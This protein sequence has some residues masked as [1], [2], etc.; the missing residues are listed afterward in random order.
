M[1]GPRRGLPHG[2]PLNTELLYYLAVFAVMSAVIIGAGVLLAKTE[3]VRSETP[4]EEDNWV[5]GL[6]WAEARGADLETW[7]FL[8]GDAQTV[9]KVIEAYKIGWTKAEA[10][11]F[12]DHTVVTFLIDPEGRIARRYLGLEHAP[13]KLLRD[14]ENVL[15]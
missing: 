11:Q 2:A 5:A 9:S 13:Q 3:D 7:S 14:L 10:D 1:S 8:T 6:E 15:S 4:L 12:P